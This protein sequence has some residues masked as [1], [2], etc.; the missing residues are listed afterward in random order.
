MDVR[1]SYVIIARIT[2]LVAVHSEKTKCEVSKE[3]NEFCSEGWAE[4]SEALQNVRG[5]FD[6]I[7]SLLFTMAIICIL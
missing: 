4:C 2:S 5:I 6:F 7:L 3:P 1:E